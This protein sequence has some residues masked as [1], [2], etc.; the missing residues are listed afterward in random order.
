MDDIK[1]KTKFFKCLANEHRLAI[2]I[3][4]KNKKSA[5]VSEISEHVRTSFKATSK[6]LLY[7]NKKGILVHNYD[8]PFVMYSLSTN[9]LKFIKDII[10]LL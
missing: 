5:S 7:L 6:H 3:F 1:D 4:L 2:V 8:A 10:S 9:S